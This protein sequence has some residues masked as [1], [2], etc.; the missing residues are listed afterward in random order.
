MDKIELNKEMR[1]K[2]ICAALNWSIQTANNNTK[3][4]QIKC[5]EESFEFYHP[6]NPKTKKPK[7]SYIFTKQICEPIILDGRENNGGYRENSGRKPKDL[8]FCEVYKVGK[9]Y[10]DSKGVYKIQLNNSVYIGSTIAGFRHRFMQHY[11]GNYCGQMLYTQQLLLNGGTFESIWIAGD[12]D[13]IETIRDK[14]KYYIQK[15][16]NDGFDMVNNRLIKKKVKNKKNTKDYRVK[17]IED[18][19]IVIDCNGEVVKEFT[20][21]EWLKLIV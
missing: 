14:E 5:I 1:Y 16:Y 7:K 18:M 13:N 10:N 9:Q 4:K 11:N 15:Y 17:N 20:A 21:S 3:K 2:D 6:I 8:E 19:Y 12:S